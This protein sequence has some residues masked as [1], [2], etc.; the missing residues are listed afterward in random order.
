MEYIRPAAELIEKGLYI[1]LHAYEYHVFMDFRQVQDDAWQSYHHLCNYLAGRGVPSISEAINE[2]MLQPVLNPFREIANPGY[3]K[4]LY[5]AQLVDAT[6][7]ISAA[8][9]DEAVNKTANLLHGMAYLLGVSGPIDDILAET[10]YT[11]Q[12]IL[13]L[14][15][16]DEIYPVPSGK[17]YSAAMTALQTPLKQNPEHWNILFAW[18]FTHGLGK[19]KSPAGFEE[20]TL[21]WL[22]EWQF[23]R[24]LADTLRLPDQ[25][26]SDA[27]RSIGLLRLLI[28]QQNWYAQSKK[29]SIR[30]I[31]ENWLGQEAIQQYLGINRYKDLLWFNREAFLDFTGWMYTL[32]VIQAGA[33]PLATASERIEQILGAYEIIERLEVI[34][35]QSDYQVVKL[36]TAAEEE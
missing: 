24:N 3:F 26:D 15:V 9:L 27:W 11:L 10:R 19:M 14:P 25:S 2:L 12:T 5:G 30:A 33:L 1:Q 4:Y 32:A 36:L 21:S 6:A 13:S 22:D 34:V 23:S 17:R 16:L 7:P 35:K 29:L 8:L 28:A 31:L 20:Q 18:V